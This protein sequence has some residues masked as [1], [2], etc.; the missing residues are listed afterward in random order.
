MHDDE[1]MMVNRTLAFTSIKYSMRMNNDEFVQPYTILTLQLHTLS[2]QAYDAYYCMS[3]KLWLIFVSFVLREE[4]MI[5]GEARLLLLTTLG[6]GYEYQITSVVYSSI[7]AYAKKSEFKCS[8]TS[9]SRF[10]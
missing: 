2:I 7:D 5:N 6:C 4:R 8:V 9:Y 10:C 1:M 3:T